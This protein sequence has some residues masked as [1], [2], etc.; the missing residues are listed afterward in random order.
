MEIM[1][2]NNLKLNDK[3]ELEIIGIANGGEGV[4]RHNNFVV[5][6]PYS[7]VNDVLEVEITE[8]SK[9][10]ARGKIVKILKSSLDRIKPI[11]KAYFENG[12]EKFCGGC[13]FMHIDYKKQVKYKENFVI[14]ALEK[15]GRIKKDEYIWDGIVGNT[16]QTVFGYRNKLQMPMAIDEKKNAYTGFF[17]PGT[18]CVVKIDECYIQPNELNLI[19]QEFVN[20]VNKFKIPVYDETKQTAAN[21]VRHLCLRTNKNKEVLLTIVGTYAQGKDGKIL[22][23]IKNLANELFEKFKGT[24]KGIVYNV[25]TENSNFVFGDKFFTICGID[26]L[27][28]KIG[29]INYKISSASFLQVNSFIAEKLYSDLKDFINPKGDEKVLDLYC[30]SGGIG[31]F[32]ANKIGK[33]IGVEISKSAAENAA[34]TASENG[35]TNA[36]YYNAKVEEILDEL[37]DE[38]ADIV[39]LNPPRKGIAE[40]VVGQIN[41]INPAK[42]IYVSCNPTTLARDLKRFKEIGYILK[43]AKAFDMFP[44]TSNV[45]TLTILERK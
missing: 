44:Q 6:V 27:T 13:D 3:I 38:N 19:F 24:V 7:A 30:G 2:E 28:E 5:F 26:E 35:I 33:L 31:L 43:R 8:L 29:E 11:C 4:G 22:E 23:N 12:K 36:L 9:T 18:H 10:F 40:E 41:K 16:E 14:N 25:N 45:E 32:I 15:I 39:I 37:C 42:I 17:A 20:L 1:V 34:L 21:G